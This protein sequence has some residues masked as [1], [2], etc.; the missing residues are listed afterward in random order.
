MNVSIAYRDSIDQ[1][2]AL[3]ERLRTRLAKINQKIHEPA[4][5]KVTLE[6]DGHLFR[7]NIAFLLKGQEVVASASDAD[8]YT[9]IDQATDR[10]EKQVR[11]AHDRATSR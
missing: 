5:Y 3:E 4:S 1:S 9:S 11:R 8:A 10:A 2:D 7:T 6:R